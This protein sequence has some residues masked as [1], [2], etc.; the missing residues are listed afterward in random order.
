MSE[1]VEKT[2]HASAVLL[3]ARACLIRGPSGSGKSRLALALLNAAAAG[4]LAFAR[5]VADDRIHLEAC[6]G[7]LLARAPGGLAGLLEVRGLG[8]RRVPYEPLAAVGWV[9]D[10]AASG[11]ERLPLPDDC[12]TTIEGVTLPRI[13][14]HACTD[15]APV[16]VAALRTQ[17]V[18]F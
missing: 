17:E 12:R 11:A 5:L 3:G 16:L 6:H 18:G 1:I 4:T 2:V 15:P 10:L 7:R 14:V 13:A 8:L 9:V